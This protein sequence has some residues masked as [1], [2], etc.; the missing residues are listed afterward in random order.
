MGETIRIEHVSKR[1]GNN[2][3]LQDVSLQCESGKIY[4]DRKSVV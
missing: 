2:V 3:V 1:F 4:G